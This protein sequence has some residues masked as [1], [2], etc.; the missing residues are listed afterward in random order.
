MYTNPST[1]DVQQAEQE[2]RSAYALTGNATAHPSRI[3]KEQAEKL[4]ASLPGCVFREEAAGGSVLFTF[5]RIAQCPAC[6]RGW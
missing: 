4:A 5:A 6:G 2:I 3:T 1:E